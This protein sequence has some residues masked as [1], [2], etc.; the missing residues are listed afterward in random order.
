MKKHTIIIA[1]MAALLLSVSPM[2]LTEAQVADD[3][4]KYKED[5]RRKYFK[6]GYNKEARENDDETPAEYSARRKSEINASKR[7][8]YI[9]KSDTSCNNMYLERDLGMCHDDLLLEYAALY[10]PED[11]PY[12]KLEDWA[13]NNADAAEDYARKEALKAIQKSKKDICA[14]YSY[15]CETQMAMEYGL[16][17]AP[18]D[19]PYDKLAEWA[20]NNAGRA[21]RAKVNEYYSVKNN[22]QSEPKTETTETSDDAGKTT[23]T[24][25]TGSGTPSGSETTDGSTTDSSSTET[26]T[27]KT[28]D[29]SD[30]DDSKK[31]EDKKEDDNNY[32]GIFNGRQIVPNTMAI[33]CKVNAEDMLKENAKLYNCINDI[34]RK[35]NDSD[36]SIRAE[37]MQRF[38]EIRYEELKTMMA[39][40]IA[41]GAAISNYENIQNELGDATGKTK[42]E[43][44]DNVAIASATS[45]LTDVIN[46][47]RDLYAERLKN[48]AIT[49]IQSIDPKV[50]KDIAE[51]ESEAANG[52]ES[53]GKDAGTG[54]AK[55]GKKDQETT[56]TSIQVTEN[57]PDIDVTWKEG[58]NCSQTVCTG[59]DN[60]T[61][62]EEVIPCPNNIY[63]INGSAGTYMV[64]INGECQKYEDDNFCDNGS[65]KEQS[66]TI[67][68]PSTGMCGDSKC[69]MGI[70]NFGGGKYACYD[71]VCTTCDTGAVITPDK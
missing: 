64:C 18:A 22:T 6:Q 21:V 8:N 40:A 45:T 56:S 59:G 42:T 28:T 38:D 41:K 16:L 9:N 31:E 15:Y 7:Y 11:V 68:D 58:N 19:V 63:P 43:H 35:I 14:H 10:A 13:K 3:S 27:N 29:V 71:D 51:Q 23:T 57:K 61:C 32:T 33:Y 54:T 62:H 36:T 70:Y 47:M 55:D 48:E 2:S 26:E 20:Q 60:G 30:S 52:D 66:G 34:A 37:N 24:T 4:D 12:D 49:G 17:N 50:I 46:T 5:M 1:F 67:T 69:P 25:T 44:E 53:K 39:Q 65:L